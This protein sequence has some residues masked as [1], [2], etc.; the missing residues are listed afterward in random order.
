MA[1]YKNTPP[2]VTDGL[3]MYLDA[4]NPKSYTSGSS[5]WNDL[6]GNKNT[7]SVSGSVSLGIINNN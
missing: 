3:A 5:T 6:S 4:S 7:A 2:I 1:T